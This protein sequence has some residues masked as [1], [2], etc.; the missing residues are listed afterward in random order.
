MSIKKYNESEQHWE[1]EARLAKERKDFKSKYPLLGKRVRRRNRKNWEEGIIILDETD[2]TDGQE[3]FI[4][5]GEDDFEQLYG[6][7]FEVWNEDTQK[8]DK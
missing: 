2:W 1:I 8:W 6:L 4:K 3:L 5:F 7:P